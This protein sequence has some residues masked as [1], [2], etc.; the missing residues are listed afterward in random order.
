MNVPT[1]ITTEIILITCTGVWPFFGFNRLFLLDPKIKL[2]RNHVVFGRCSRIF[3][4][5]R[6]LF[7]VFVSLSFSR[8]A[9]GEKAATVF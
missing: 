7:A 3:P 1:K 5:F 4:L 9:V 2:G 6:C 8:V